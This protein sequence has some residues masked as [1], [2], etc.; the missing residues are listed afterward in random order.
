VITASRPTRRPPRLL[1]REVGPLTILAVVVAYAAL[2]LVARPANTPT[3]SYIGQWCG[4]E[5]V[6]L[7]SVSLVLI[8]TLPWVEMWFDGID[9]AAVWHRRVAMIGL[10]LLLPH[11]LLSTGAG[12][13]RL[14][15]IVGLLGLVALVVWASCPAGNRSSRDPCA[16]SC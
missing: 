2:W 1:A 15:G 14:L 11:V 8:S 6:L 10:G 13:G 5:S 4:A 7:L 16:R 9:R 12:G 3:A